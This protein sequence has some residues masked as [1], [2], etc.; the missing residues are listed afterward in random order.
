MSSAIE[1]KQI[2]TRRDLDAFIRFPWKVYRGD[3]NWVP[4]LLSERRNRLNPEKNPFFDRARVEYYM[5]SRGKEILG[6]VAAFV[7]QRSNERLGTNLGGFGFFEVL[8]DYEAAAALLDTV[9][10]RMREWD[11]E[12]FWGPTN[13]GRND[14]PGFLIKETDMPPALLEAHTPLYYSE[15]AERYGMVKKQDFYAWRAFLPDLGT[16]LEKLP[17]QLIRV[18]DATEKR[19]GVLVRKVRMNDWDNE[20]ETARYL[21][22]TTLTHLPDHVPMDRETWGRFANQMRTFLDPDLALI[23]EV[24]DKPVGFLVC[25]PDINRVLIHLNGRMFP[26]GWLKMLWYSRRIDVVSFKLFGLLEQYRRRGIDVLLYLRAVRE[27]AAKGYRWLDGSLTS[28]FNPTV[29]RLAER[30]G[31]ERYKHYRLYEMIIGR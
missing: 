30:L 9:V 1:V 12:G 21:F 29:V 24:E 2:L 28:E 17:E 7:D 8:A 18:F 6:T 15:F 19:G 5:A 23:A 13:F 22:N 25:F 26:F 3:P 4:P 11:V 27:A 10:A 14:E 20:L 31:A 16:N